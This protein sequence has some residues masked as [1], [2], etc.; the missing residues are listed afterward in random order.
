MHGD[1]SDCRRLSLSLKP[2]NS[3]NLAKGVKLYVMTVAVLGLEYGQG[4][5]EK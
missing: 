4:L 1:G 5:F 2:T 3:L